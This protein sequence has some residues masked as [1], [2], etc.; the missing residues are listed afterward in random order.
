MS[1]L[2]D[3]LDRIL[4][5]LQQHKPSYVFSLQAGLSYQ[6]IEE[7]VKDL[8]FRLTREVYE[9]YQWHNGMIDEDSSF[10]YDYRFLSLE[11]ALEVQ[12]I[13]SDNYG[14]ILP[15]G[16]FPIFEFENDGF[17][18]VCAEEITE[19]SPIL[20]YTL[21]EEIRY[22]SL[23][24]MMRCIAECYETGAYY[25]DESCDF[26]KDDILANSILQKY[27]PEL[28]Y[29][30]EAR[31]ELINVPDGSQVINKYHPD[32]QILETSVIDD[33]GN[34]KESTR[35]FQ[36]QVVEHRTLS[37]K[38]DSFYSYHCN[39]F[40]LND[41]VKDERF[42]VEYQYKCVMTK[43][44]RRYVNGN[45]KQ[46]IIHPDKPRDRS[47]FI[48]TLIFTFLILPII[49]IISFFAMIIASLK[50]PQRNL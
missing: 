9:L 39:E 23:T 25:I 40:W 44:E 49:N 11:E 13:V 29:M 50:N 14:F 36:G 48:L 2:T 6:E 46:E 7:K 17:A 22:S 8:P 24:N 26:K 27:E 31:F 32:N 19:S 21:S 4:N 47:L 45:L 43:I 12:K 10:F 20:N 33:K 16:W 34:I 30:G 18:I 3:A 38:I 28:H 42:E 15:F 41:Y 5:W 1:E 37:Y 35:Y